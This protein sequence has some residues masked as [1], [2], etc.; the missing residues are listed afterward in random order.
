[1][2]KIH[3]SKFIFSL[4]CCSIVILGACSSQ[5]ASYMSEDSE[6]V[7]AKFSIEKEYIVASLPLNHKNHDEFDTLSELY[8]SSA[9]GPLHIAIGIDAEHSNEKDI[10]KARKNVQ[11][12]ADHFRKN[13]IQNIEISL[14]PVMK[15]NPNLTVV[16]FETIKVSASEKCKDQVMPGYYSAT[17]VDLGHYPLGCQNAHVMRKQIANPRDLAGRA[18]LGGQNDAN[19][20]GNVI[21]N[22][23]RTGETQEYL[24]GFIISELG[25]SGG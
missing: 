8:T 5:R 2:I 21:D 19:R 18:N 23:Y 17:T 4:L 6:V 7:N 24:P 20:A 10:A 11:R 13:N 14:A 15:A 9:N 25:G 1:M 12:V 22:T 3:S 16:G